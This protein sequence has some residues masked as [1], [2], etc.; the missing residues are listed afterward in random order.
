[1]FFISTNCFVLKLACFDRE[2]LGQE[3]FKFLFYLLSSVFNLFSSFIKFQYNTAQTLNSNCLSL[4]NVL[5]MCLH[6]SAT[7]LAA[8]EGFGDPLG[9]AS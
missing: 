8:P 9:N 4:Q 3:P 7:P 1:M 6:L 2:S 5:E